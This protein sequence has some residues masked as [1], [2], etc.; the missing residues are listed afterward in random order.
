[1]KAFTALLSAGV[2][3]AVLT[4]AAF[5]DE[6]APAA[7]PADAPAA[8]AAFWDSFTLGAELEAGITANYD[9]NHS[10]VNYGHLFTDR[11][12][13]ILLNQLS[14][15]A[16]RPVDPKA[17]DFD[18]GFKFEGFYGTDARYT[19]FLGELDK[20]IKDRTQFDIVEASISAHLPIL[21]DGGV[22][23]KVGQFPTPIGFEVIEPTGNPFYS[24]SYIFNFGIPLKHTGGYVTAHLNDTFDL[25]LGGTTGVNTSVGDGDNNDSASFLGGLGINNLAGGA[26]TVLAL[27][28]IGPENPSIIAPFVNFNP[29]DALRYL[30]DIV[31]T[32]KAS[33]TLT[34]TTE[35]NYIRDDGFHAQAWGAAQYLSYA[36]SDNLTWN[37]R[38]EVYHDGGQNGGGFFVG[39][40]PHN[41]DFVDAEEGLPNSSFGFVRATYSEW[42]AG[43]TIK[44]DVPDIIKG[45]M[46]RPELRLDSTLDGRRMYGDLS[47]TTQFTAGLDVV[48]PLAIYPPP[49]PAV[50]APPPPAPAAPPPAPAPAPA[51]EAARSFQVF[52]DFDKSDITAAAAKV[53]QAAADNTKAGNVSK[54]MVTGHTD[55]VGA[56]AYNQALSERRAAAVKKQLVADGVPAGGIMTMGVGKTGLLVPTPD[57]VREPQN[58]RAEIVLQ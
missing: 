7:A 55:T 15:S 8:P 9:D 24:H 56:A 2:S 10:G 40:F 14:L 21:T 18:W 44:P 16:A 47:K 42:T 6:P 31:I 34:L 57:G 17:T 48:I 3:M 58:R 20:S 35:L 41:L 19:H 5:A 27:T 50:E 54:L 43:A 1:M 12:N 26:L 33:D 46:I 29:N 52:F 53:I 28:S 37:L 51:V 25:W 49:S 32:Y 13:Q 11:E 4:A 38:G 36:A 23:M 30:N 39:A 45:L 22:D